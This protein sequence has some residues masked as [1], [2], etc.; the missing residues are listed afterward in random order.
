MTF[1][2]VVSNNDTLLNK[3]TSCLDCSD[4]VIGVFLDLKKPLILLIT[5]YFKKLYIYAYA[6]RGVA[7]K[8][9]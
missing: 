9:L 4:L 2:I 3:I 7:L 6:I 5:K 8:L 1:S